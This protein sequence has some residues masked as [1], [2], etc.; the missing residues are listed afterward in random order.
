MPPP[1]RR[2]RSAERTREE[3]GSR[4][5]VTRL[6]LAIP[7]PFPANASG[8]RTRGQRLCAGLSLYWSYMGESGFV[9]NNK[10]VN[11]EEI[12]NGRFESTESGPSSAHWV[13]TA[14]LRQAASP[15]PATEHGGL[16]PRH[17]FAPGAG[18]GGRPAFGREEAMDTVEDGASK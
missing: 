2:P 15:T 5:Y 1:A 7:T 10:D 4:Y 3:P 9:V 17:V 6:L 8:V 18:R 11:D 14:R 16:D 12:K 13:N